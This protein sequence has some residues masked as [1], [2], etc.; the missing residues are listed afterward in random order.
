M[1]TLVWRVCPR[2]SWRRFTSSA[3]FRRA[4]TPLGAPAGGFVAVQ[5]NLRGYG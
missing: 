1:A 5:R 2:P 4:L 3:L